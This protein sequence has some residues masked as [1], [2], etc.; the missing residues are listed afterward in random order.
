MSCQMAEEL[1]QLL[2]R[3]MS[4]LVH[5]LMSWS[6]EQVLVLVLA[7]L[8]DVL[9]IGG[10]SDQRG[11]LRWQFASV[12][13]VLDALRHMYCSTEDADGASSDGQWIH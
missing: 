8:Q 2:L 9:Q 4:M 7:L 6:M 13:E 1:F 10:F 11:E 3:C 12:L 5:L